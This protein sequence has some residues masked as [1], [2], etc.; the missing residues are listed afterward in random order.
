MAT[1]AR[2]TTGKRS[3]A[4]SHVSFLKYA[5]YRWLKIAAGL[6]A[7][8]ILTYALIDVE[9]RPSGSS[10]YGYT[11][12]TIGAGLIVWLALL[13]LRKRT[14]RPGQWTLKSWVSAHVW[15][16]LSL[17]VIATLHCA[18]QFG[19]NVHTLAYVLMMAVILSGVYGICAYTILPRQLSANRGEMTQAE[20]LDN[21]RSIDRQL[22]D[23]AQPLNSD[24]AQIIGAS[25]D[26]DPFAGNVFARLR[27]S[28]PNCPTQLAFAEVSAAAR[29]RSAAGAED[30][31]RAVQ[32]L[33]RKVSALS[34][35]RRHLQIKAQ[36]D[37]WLYVHVPLTFALVA[38]L[39]A[40]VI[41]VFFY[42]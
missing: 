5:D 42:W 21:L 6:S 33:S 12:G 1:P 40:H 31:A 15:L 10:W 7:L 26:D 3:G 25:L 37:V 18:F 19:W 38:A 34:H 20:M 27:N 13:G 36:L 4:S 22:H 11:L 2:K 24:L 9:P 35:I 32:I 14:I 29:D 16:G 41:S 39:F 28:Y 23:A 8:A 17:I 30:I